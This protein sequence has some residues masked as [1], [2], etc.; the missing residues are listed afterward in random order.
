MLKFIL[1]LIT[2][3]FTLALTAILMVLGIK[4]GYYAITNYPVSFIVILVGL[5][6]LARVTYESGKYKVAKYFYQKQVG[7]ID[8]I[9]AFTK[10]KENDIESYI[11][12]YLDSNKLELLVKSPKIYKW[13]EDIKYPEGMISRNIT[14]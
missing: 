12:E 3:C 2:W 11:Q 9:K 7:S 1:L 6:I 13:T 4:I 14:L 8:D 10:L 5:V